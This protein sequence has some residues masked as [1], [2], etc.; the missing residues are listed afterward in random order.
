MTNAIVVAALLTI[1][2]LQIDVQSLVEL[3]QQTRI[4]FTTVENSIYVRFF[5][6]SC[7]CL[8]CHP[9]YTDKKVS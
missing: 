8:S 4:N 6:S 3:S 2:S 9:T 1:E 5:H 7:L